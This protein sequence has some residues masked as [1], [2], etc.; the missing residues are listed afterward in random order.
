M[1]KRRA[2]LIAVAVLGVLLVPLAARALILNNGMIVVENHTSSAIRVYL[3]H[4]LNAG[5][6]IDE[7]SLEPGQTWRSQKCCFA[8][9]SPYSMRVYRHAPAPMGG[10][11]AK[12]FAPRLCNRNGIPYGYDV[13]IMDNDNQIV[14]QH[15]HVCYEGPL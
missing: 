2:M 1:H 8:A 5:H 6:F 7:G 10:N 11:Y 9:W 14:E 15:T 4:P 13:L 12:S 3:E